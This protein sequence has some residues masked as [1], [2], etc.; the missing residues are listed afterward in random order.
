[1][2]ADDA[3]PCRNSA[4]PRLE[5]ARAR[6]AKGGQYKPLPTKEEA[7]QASKPEQAVAVE[8]TIPFEAAVGLLPTPVSGKVRYA[9]GSQDELGERRQNVAFESRPYSW[10]RAPTNAW[11]VYAGPFRSYK[12]LV[13]LGVGS[14]YHI[15]MSGMEH[16]SVHIGDYVA[17]GE[18]IGRMGEKKSDNNTNNQPLFFGEPLLYVEF[19]K[20]VKPID[21]TPWWAKI[22]VEDNN[23][24]S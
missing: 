24:D 3:L 16:I 7:E 6:I 19:R 12:K 9:F 2:A 15:I 1:M 11:V 20:G 14:G 4:L 17:Q 18:P 13:I 5:L 23:D 8:D 10:V 21:P 22:N